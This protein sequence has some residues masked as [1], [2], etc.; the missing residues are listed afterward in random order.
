[1]NSFLNFILIKVVCFFLSVLSQSHHRIDLCN[2]R[3]Q[4]DFI[5]MQCVITN[6][7]WHGK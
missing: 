6:I 7:R 5:P 1:M 3:L 2:P 4:S